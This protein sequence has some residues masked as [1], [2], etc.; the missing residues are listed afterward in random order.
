MLDFGS[1]G[2]VVL[3]FASGI[4]F[5]YF[6]ENIRGLKM[7]YFGHGNVRS[8]V[9]VLVVDFLVAAIACCGSDFGLN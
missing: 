7:C 4:G 3:G 2:A 5:G 9:A 1:V 6:L 8:G